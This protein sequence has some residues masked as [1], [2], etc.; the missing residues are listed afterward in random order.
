MANQVDVTPASGPTGLNLHFHGPAGNTAS[1]F[2][3]PSDFPAPS[4]SGTQVTAKIAQANGGPRFCN[5]S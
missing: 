4:K 3:N 2:N 1:V 5:P